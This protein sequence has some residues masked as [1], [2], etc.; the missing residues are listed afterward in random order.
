V[1]AGARNRRDL[2]SG[3]WP[4]DAAYCAGPNG[5]DRA[6]SPAPGATRRSQPAIRQGLLAAVHTSPH[7]AAA[8]SAVLPLSWTE[9]RTLERLR[10][11]RAASEPAPPGAHVEHV[12]HEVPDASQQTF[13]DGTFA[14][15]WVV[16][17]VSGRTDARSVYQRVRDSESA[18]DAAQP[19]PELRWSGPVAFQ[20]LPA[21]CDAPPARGRQPARGARASGLG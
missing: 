21:S 6:R 4:L 17:R 10:L 18:V 8:L 13:Y 20:A 19:A 1:V 3:G 5:R 14:G 2:P 11:L 9:R 12:E 15:R 16:E 7:D